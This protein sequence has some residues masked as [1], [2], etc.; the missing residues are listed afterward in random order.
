MSQN[1]TALVYDYDGTLAMGNVQEHS[2]IPEMGFTKEEFWAEVN[3]RAKRHDADEVLTYMG[4]MLEVARE[5]GHP[6]TRAALEAHGEGTQLFGGLDDWFDR[7]NA[8][9]AERGLTI[10]HYIIS[11]GNRELISASPI[12][13]RFTRV[14][15][16]KFIFDDAGNAVWPGLAINYTNKTQFLFRINKGIDNSWDSHAINA[17]I[18]MADRP[19][20]FERMIFFGDG[21]TDIPAMKTVRQQGGCS[22][23]VFDP[24]DFLLDAT[25]EKISRLISEDRVHYVAP[26]DYSP[27]SQL[28][29]VTRGVLGRIARQREL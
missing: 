28:D 21:A 24:E 5:K 4:Y 15:A 3:A 27:G 9:G 2:F 17:W 26:A 23:A 10:E 22:I 8:F 13:D 25:Q 7:I 19:V 1:R 29:V 16:S 20:P 12:F 6:V 18:P 14:Y 11:S